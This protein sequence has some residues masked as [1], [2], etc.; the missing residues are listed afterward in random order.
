MAQKCRFSQDDQAFGRLNDGCD[1]PQ[2]L[3]APSPGRS[4][5][6]LL[7]SGES[8]RVPCLQHGGAVADQAA[9]L[10][11][12]Q[13]SAEILT[14]PPPAPPVPCA[15]TSV[16]DA[17]GCAPGSGWSGGSAGG[18]AD[19]GSTNPPEAASCILAQPGGPP[20]PPRPPAPAPPAGGGG[21]D[22]GGDGASGCGIAA[23]VDGR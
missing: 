19:G 18:C 2:L 9:R 6:A 3:P 14:A 17:C 1:T 21:G 23:D 7:P 22:S 13:T 11:R 15:D 20:P 16:P 10:A 5:A 8:P 12:A 4:N